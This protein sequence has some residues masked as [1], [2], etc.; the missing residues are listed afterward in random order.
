MGSTGRGP[1]VVRSG[2]EEPAR[3]L[4]PA[5]STSI[6]GIRGAVRC[7]RFQ[8]MPS[9]KDAWEA[10]TDSMRASSPGGAGYILT[11]QSDCGIRRIEKPEQELLAGY[12]VTIGASR[13]RCLGRRRGFRSLRK[14]L[15]KKSYR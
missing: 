13:L 5:G 14:R 2:K 3:R 11:G 6:Q 4:T 12:A 10:N 15:V 9:G 7:R 8:L 1:P